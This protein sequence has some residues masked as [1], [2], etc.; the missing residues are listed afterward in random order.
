MSDIL[1]VFRS[2]SPVVVLFTV[3]Y[4]LKRFRFFQ[5][6]SIDDL[7]KLVLS[8]AL[9]ALLFTVFSNLKLSRDLLIC[10][11]IV[12]TTCSFL[13]GLGVLIA[14]AFSLRSA[15][16]PFMFTG[17]ET[18]M[19]GYAIFIAVFGTD[20][21]PALASFDLG[22]LF[23]VWIVLVGPLLRLKTRIRKPAEI[24]VMFFRSPVVIGILAGLAVNVLQQFMTVPV[25]VLGMVNSIARTTSLVTVPL[26]SI[27]I[28]YGFTVDRRTLRDSLLTILLRVPATLGLAFFLD[29][30]LLRNILFFTPMYQAAFI[31]MFLLPPPFVYTL[32]LHPQDEE[33]A[34]YLAT[35]YSLHTL[36]S[37]ALFIIVVPQIV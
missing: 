20:E 37:I 34:E 7:R 10:F 27:I 31:T 14:R 2:T 35:T 6:G 24:V 11:A 22:Q 29:R 16:A 12:F 5:T 36:L 19:L 17:F 23:F 26:I 28:G 18:G 4:L 1:E 33:N 21:T 13:I 15:Y 25:M 32:F 3:G 9:P 30:F 8:I